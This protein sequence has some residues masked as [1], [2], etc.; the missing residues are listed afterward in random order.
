MGKNP[1]SDDGENPSLVGS[2]KSFLE[3]RQGSEATIRRLAQMLAD[4]RAR[5]AAVK[6]QKKNPNEKLQESKRNPTTVRNALT[7]ALESVP[8][9]SV[10]AHTGIMTGLGAAYGNMVQTG[11]SITGP[12]IGGTVGAA[13]AASI[14]GREFVKQY[15]KARKDPHGNKKAEYIRAG[16]RAEKAS[17]QSDNAGLAHEVLQT[18]FP[19][20]SPKSLRGKIRDWVGHRSD[21]KHKEFFAHHKEME[22]MRKVWSEIT[23]SVKQLSEEKGISNK[24]ALKEMV[25][26]EKWKEPNAIQ[27]FLGIRPKE[28][29]W[30]RTSALERKN[31]A[32]M[33]AKLN[34][35]QDSSKETDRMYRINDILLKWVSNGSEKWALQQRKE[36]PREKTFGYMKTKKEDGK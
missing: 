13:S 21:E 26:S 30:D 12:V 10:A 35:G 6:K 25:L 2:L 11:D 36:R 20:A 32:A 18:M 15:R 1:K 31:N 33:D 34:A 27:K 8:L 9:S 3:T 17:R 22:K 23:E 28:S 7:S 19:N 16:K 5:E 4:K 14:S 24:E 29:V